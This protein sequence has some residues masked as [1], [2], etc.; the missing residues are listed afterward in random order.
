M[1]DEGAEFQTPERIRISL[2]IYFWHFV[3]LRIWAFAGHGCHR[4]PNPMAATV[5]LALASG[6][7]AAFAGF[8]PSQTCLSRALPHSPRSYAHI[9]QTHSCIGSNSLQ[10]IPEQMESERT[11]EVVKFLEF[12]EL[13]KTSHKNS[14]PKKIVFWVRCYLNLLDCKQL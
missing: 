3:L 8:S 9:I 12:F 14:P 5:L 1:G 6:F 10:C 13:R 2:V 4:C 11:R 7:V